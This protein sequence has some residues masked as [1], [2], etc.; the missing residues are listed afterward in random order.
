MKVLSDDGYLKGSSTRAVYSKNKFSKL[1]RSKL[2]KMAHLGYVYTNELNLHRHIGTVEAQLEQPLFKLVLCVLP[3]GNG[4]WKPPT[5]KIWLVPQPSYLYKQQYS[6]AWEFPRHCLIYQS[7]YIAL[8]FKAISKCHISCTYSL[9][10]GQLLS[11]I[12]QSWPLQTFIYSLH[13]VWLLHCNCVKSQSFKC[14]S[15]CHKLIKMS[16]TGA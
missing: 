16:Q 13:C 11:V 12:N 8:L 9:I 7:R 1:E 10:Q 2:Q 15:C 3:I 5:S 14:K 6:S 4:S